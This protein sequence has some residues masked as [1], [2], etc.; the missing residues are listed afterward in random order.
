MCVCVCVRATCASARCI[1]SPGTGIW[2]VCVCTH[3]FAIVHSIRSCKSPIVQEPTA[4]ASF[5][6]SPFYVTCGMRYKNWSICRSLDSMSTASNV[7]NRRAERLGTRLPECEAQSLTR[8]TPHHHTEEVGEEVLQLLI[9][10]GTNT[11]ID[12]C[13]RCWLWAA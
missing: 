12:C 1:S 7:K 8:P 11:C 10:F 2:C 13:L 6:V 9:S 3:V 5:P 4:L